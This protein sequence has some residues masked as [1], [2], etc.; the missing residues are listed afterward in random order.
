MQDRVRRYAEETLRR[1]G[2]AVQIRVGLNSGEVVVR[3]IANDL[4]MDYSAMGQTVHL[5]SRMEQLATPGT[6]RLTPETLRLVEGFV[7]ARPLGPIPVKGLSEPLDIFELLGSGAARTR[8]QA[9]VTRGLTRFIGR[10][11]ELEA[12]GEALERAARDH[13]QVVALVG[14]PGVGKSRLV[15]EATHS[16][17]SSGWLVLETGA[18]SYG[19]T[20]PYLPVVELLRTYFQ[21]EARAEPTAARRRVAGGVLALDPALEPAL[22]ALLALLDLGADDPAWQALDPPRRRRRT[23]DAVRLLLVRESQVQPLLLV[24]EDLHWIDVQTQ[25]LLDGLVESL[26]TARI[27]LL[28]NYRPEYRHEWGNKTYYTQLRIDRLRPASAEELLRSLV[29]DDSAVDPLKRLLIERTEG[30]PLF[31]EESVRALVD[32]GVLVGERGAY[33]LTRDPPGIQ[34]P[35]TVQAVLAARIDR[36]P[37]ED[38]RLLETA[39]VIGKDFPFALL[40]AIAEMSEDELQRGLARLQ[41]AEFVYEASLFPEPE[42]TF[43]HALTHEV[44]Y[45]SLLQERRR[46]LHACVVGALEHLRGDRLAEQV[47]RAAHHAMRGQM[48]DKALLY[49]RQAGARAVERSANR[50]AVAWFEQALEAASRLAP[51]REMLEHAIDLRFDL[52]TALIPLGELG[53]IGGHLREAEHAAEAIRDKRRLGWIS[54]YLS[55]HRFMTGDNEGAVESGL[56]GL[57]LGEDLGDLSIDVAASVYLGQAYFVLGEYHRAMD[58]LGRNVE[59]LTGDLALDRFGQPFL[60]AVHT[61]NWMVWCHAERGEFAEAAARGEEAVRTAQAAH[62]PFSMAAAD[63][64]LGMM[65]IRRGELPEAIRVLERGVEVCRGRDVPLWSHRLSSA[66]GY[67]HALR[68][69]FSEARPLLEHAVEQDA[70]MKFAVSHSLAVAHLG[71]ERLLEGRPDEAS[72]LAERAVALSRA[73]RERGIEAWSLRLLGEIASRREPPAA[74]QAE[75][76]FGQAL[77]LAGELGMP[78]LQAHCH[79]GLGALCRKTGRPDDARA[80]LSTAIEMLRS[81]VMSHWIPQAEAELVDALAAPSVNQVG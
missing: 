40:R 5:A 27:L 70:T 80:E 61:R 28:V 20:T 66:L 4:R 50:E 36:L 77:A 12:L 25:A 6:I 23:I 65:H 46:A 13:G 10:E 16:A 24:F 32:S 68:G 47:E 39:A 1:Y 15:R 17:R 72:R 73:R 18:V 14:E 26:P 31:L 33:R 78:P 7:E 42:Y 76:H 44:A 71:E 53:Q 59:R 49:C 29:G 8:F 75:G 22:P 9:S 55:A 67:A 2:I 11:A 48:W 52:R 45:G 79:L 81:M 35:T 63:F 74:A 69:R 60:P 37:A 54:A 38:K 62:H 57:S 21:I 56:R 64:S 41:A 51:E 19:M 43:K 34:V 30:N 3:A 58:V